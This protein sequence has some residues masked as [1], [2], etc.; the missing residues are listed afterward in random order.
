[1]SIMRQIYDI[2]NRTKRILIILSSAIILFLLLITNG[3]PHDDVLNFYEHSE[4]IKSGLLPYKDFV[5]EFPPF[6]LLFFL[7]PGLFTSDLNT[8]SFIFGAMVVIFIL[9]SMYYLQKMCEMIHVNEITT[10]IL[11]LVFFIIYFPVNKFDV[12]VMCITLISIYCFMNRKIGMAYGLATFAAFTK[13]YP[14]LIIL[15][16]LLINLF[17]K[18]DNKCKNIVCGLI[19]CAIITAIAIVPLMIAGVSFTEIISFV[20]FHSERGFHVESVFAVTVMLLS[21]LGLTSYSLVAAHY[22]CD[23]ISPICDMFLPYWTAI[24]GLILIFSTIIIVKCIYNQNFNNRVLIISCMVIITTFVL[25]NKVF[26]TQYMV[27]IFPMMAIIPMITKRK[28]NRIIMIAMNISMVLACN[29]YLEQEIGNIA[30]IYLNAYK[31]IILTILFAICIYSLIKPE[32]SQLE[33]TDNIRNNE[34]NL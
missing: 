6:S 27:W 21:S 12:F 33:L 34:N 15:I 11:F 20:G 32:K 5:F 14:I 4:S 8:Y 18:E 25:T 19:S 10:S 29:L 17:G 30:Y 24:T 2:D 3:P 23:V 13:M 9:I 26:S 31:D 22:T 28:N 7:I 1:M 16:F